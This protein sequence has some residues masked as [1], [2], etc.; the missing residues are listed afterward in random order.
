M[1]TALTWNITFHSFRGKVS[2]ERNFSH[3]IHH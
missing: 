3:R 1:A 2:L